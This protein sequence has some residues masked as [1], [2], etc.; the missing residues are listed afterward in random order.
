MIQAGESL[1]RCKAR[2]PMR[3][4]LCLKA[5]CTRG[6]TWWRER[7]IH[8]RARRC[9]GRL[10]FS[11]MK[12]FTVGGPS[13]PDSR[14][15]RFPATQFPELVQHM[16]ELA[17]RLVGLMSDRIREVTRIEQQQ[18]RLASLGKLSAGLAHELNNP[19]SAAKRATS[20]LRDV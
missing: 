20:Q 19:A 18:D 15:L 6:A 11:R 9:G 16:P 3:C 2:P 7:R 1:H 5:S 12:Q 4:S 17:S 8:L 14:V 10:P 13:R